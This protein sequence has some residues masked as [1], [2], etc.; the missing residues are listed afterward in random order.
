MLELSDHRHPAAEGARRIVD[1]AWAELRAISKS[2]SVACALV[3]HPPP[4]PATPGSRCASAQT[5][6][7]SP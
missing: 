3:S 6:G 5:G 4:V 2:A 1:D 7:W